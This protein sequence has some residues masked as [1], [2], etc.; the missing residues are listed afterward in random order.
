MAGKE[1][2]D[3]G[4]ALKYSNI[5]DKLEYLPISSKAA[6]ILYNATRKSLECVVN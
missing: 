2:T 3:N 6:R 4:L 5:L 1:C